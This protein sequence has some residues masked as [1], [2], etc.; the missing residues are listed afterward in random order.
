MGADHFK[1]NFFGVS[2][3]LKGLELE[4]GKTAFC[5]SPFII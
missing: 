3:I 4:C 5:Y 1:P 2:Y